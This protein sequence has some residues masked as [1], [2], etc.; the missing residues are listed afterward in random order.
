MP[1]AAR[2]LLTLSVVALGAA[3]YLSA[4]GGI[5]PLVASLGGSLD[6]AFGKLVATPI[7]SATEAIATDS[8]LI[9]VPEHPF[10]NVANA[11]QFD[12]AHGRGSA[13]AS[14]GVTNRPSV[15]QMKAGKSGRAAATASR[16]CRTPARDV[17]GQ[18]K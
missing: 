9:A 16:M 4:T 7:P 18:T 10:T 5:G 8:P 1:L 3:V 15:R 11:N 17:G 12:A 14:V 2:G 6:A 13:R